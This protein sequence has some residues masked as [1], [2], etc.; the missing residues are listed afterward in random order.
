[1]EKIDLITIGAHQRSGAT[2]EQCQQIVQQVYASI[3]NGKSILIRENDH[4]ATIISSF[5]CAGTDIEIDRLTPSI[6]TCAGQII[7]LCDVVS[8]VTGLTLMEHGKDAL[9][10]KGIDFYNR[11]QKNFPIYKTIFDLQ[12]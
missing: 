11:F 5:C 3:K 9:K 6:F 1:M 4:S 12:L 7:D 8:K 10:Q 2:I